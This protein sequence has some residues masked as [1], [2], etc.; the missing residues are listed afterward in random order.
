MVV[1]V[2]A[3]STVLED[4]SQHLAPR[5]GKLATRLIKSFHP[6][7]DPADADRLA[8]IEKVLAFAAEAEQCL[9]EQR[10][11]IAEL[12]SMSMTDGLT[13]IPNRRALED[14]CKRALATAKR[15]G[16]SG[17]MAYFDLDNFKAIN[18]AF[19]HAVGDK[20]LRH[21]ARIL[22]DNSRVCDFVG[23]M[24]GD[25]FVIFMARTNAVQA[26]KHA[27]RL[28]ALIADSDLRHNGRKLP[29]NVSFGIAVYGAETQAATL[30]SAA[31]RAMYRNKRAQRARHRLAAAG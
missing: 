11:R 21:V 12:E 5:M 13:G 4:V 24:H 1:E 8:L 19:G 31:D 18:D 9:A 30:L 20:V 25:E 17:S 3:L 22:T 26:A 2:A 16:E 7:A 28:Q 6:K 27:H 29:I 15:Y 23:R 10:R 14:H